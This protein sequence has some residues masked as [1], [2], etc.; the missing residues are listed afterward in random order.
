M[1][2]LLSLPLDAVK[3]VIQGQDMRGGASPPMRPAALEVA[4]KLVRTRGIGG[5]YSGVGPSVLRAFLV[6]G[7]RFTAYEAAMSAL[8]DGAVR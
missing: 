6:T 1:A 7:S 8:A 4:R 3:T 5:L 2:W